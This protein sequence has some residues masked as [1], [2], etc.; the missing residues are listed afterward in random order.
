M[1]RSLD[2]SFPD[3]LFSWIHRSFSVVAEQILLY[4]GSR[5]VL[6]K[7]PPTKTMNR[8]FTVSTLGRK[9]QGIPDLSVSISMAKNLSNMAVLQHVSLFRNNE[10]YKLS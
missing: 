1:Q 8:D 3:V 9:G 5:I 7:D 4:V 6:I 10:M 2:L